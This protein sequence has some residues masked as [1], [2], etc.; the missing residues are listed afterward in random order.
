VNLKLI[1]AGVPKD[2]IMII[3]T[4]LYAVKIIIPV[5]AVKYTSGPK[6][7]STYLNVTPFRYSNLNINYLLTLIKFS[8]KTL[9]LNT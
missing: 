7:I 1:D 3:Q 4:G 2:N 9:T 8:L 5:I 6:P